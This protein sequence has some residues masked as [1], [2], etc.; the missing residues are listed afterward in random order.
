MLMRKWQERF[1]GLFP[2]N[3]FIEQPQK[4][5]SHDSPEDFDIV[6]PPEFGEDQEQNHGGDDS[7]QDVE[8]APE[9]EEAAGE[10]AG[11]QEAGESEE[12]DSEDSQSESS[13]DSDDSDSESGEENESDFGDSESDEE[14]ESGS[15]EEEDD[16][17]DD[18]SESDESENNSDED[19][20]ERNYRQAFD[21]EEARRRRLSNI[22]AVIVSKV[23]EDL[24][25]WPVEGDDEWDVQTLMERRITR[26]P[27][28]HCRQS[29]DRES[30]IVILDTSGSCWEQASFYSRIADA[31]V[32]RGDVELYTAPNAGLQARRTNKGWERV[33]YEWPF[34]GRTIIFFGDFDGGDAVVEASR[35]NKIY[36]FSCE[37]DRYRD[38]H[39]HSW[40][41]YTLADFR[42]HYFDCGT[43]EDF[44]RLARKVR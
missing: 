18:W 12:S 23:A 31:A 3:D 22:F 15:S 42:G 13:E 16:E 35:I 1:A 4:Q 34:R 9:R 19:E 36:W 10:A 28:S 8:D 39:E 7:C 43:E 20:G 21:L 11:E 2:L 33:N 44:I 5:E 40:C 29:R 14:S 30:V 24:T 37:G 27:L 17:D 6:E 32:Q 38:M 25:G 41:H 26:R